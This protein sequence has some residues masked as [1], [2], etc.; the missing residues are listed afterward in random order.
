MRDTLRGGQRPIQQGTGKRP[1]ASCRDHGP[2][3]GEF[4]LEQRLFSVT[5]YPVLF[6]AEPRQT[7][8]VIA[9]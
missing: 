6:I 8:A 3:S 7:K 4:T 5:S 2:I 1:A 9:D